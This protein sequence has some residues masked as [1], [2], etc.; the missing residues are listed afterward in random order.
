MNRR[1]IVVIQFHDTLHVFRAGRGTG[2]A[3]LESNMLQQLMEMRE[4]GIYEI[5]LDLNKSFD[6][7]DRGLC[8]NILEANGVGSHSIRLLWRYWERFTI[9]ARAGG[10]FGYPFMVHRGMTQEGQ[11]Y[12][13]ISK[14][15]VDT[16]LR[17]WVTM[18][19]ATEE[20]E[21]PST[22]GFRRGIQGLA[23][24]LYA[25]D[26]QLASTQAHHLNQALNVM[27]ELFVRAGMHNNVDKTVSMVC[28]PCRSIWGHYA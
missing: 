2:T 20:T 4:E 10:Y 3:S 16:V 5:F 23:A 28:R 26:S 13:T 15:M 1:L 22:E 19:A 17:N 6:A 11:L 9:V 27:K 8:L 25:E 24:Y 21:D 12:P 14:V 18:V 7:L